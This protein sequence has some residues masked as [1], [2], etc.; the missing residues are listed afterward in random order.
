MTQR[1]PTSPFVDSGGAMNPRIRSWK[2][3][4]VW[5]IGASTGIGAATASLLLSKGAQVALSARNA[6]ALQALADNN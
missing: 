3:A 5:L 4:R 1:A 6:S 2:G